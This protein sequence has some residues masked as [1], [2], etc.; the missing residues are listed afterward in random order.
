M[1]KTVA[2]KSI[3]LNFIMNVLLTISSFVFPLISFPYVSRILQPEGTGR[4]SF[5]ISFISY[6]SL[7]AQLG[8]PIYGIRACAK[9]RDNR[10]DLTRTAHEL[11]F[12]NLITS[13]ISYAA[14][15]VALI[16]IEKLKEDR[17]LFIIVSFTIILN[18]IGMEWLYKALEQYTYITVRSIILKFIALILMFIVIHDKEDYVLYGGISIF[19]T[20][21]SNIFNMINIYKYIDLRPVGNYNVKKHLKPIGIF[22]AMTCATTI[23]THMDTLM[24][25]FMSTY[26]DVG[27]YNAAIRVKNILVSIVTSL[28]TVLLP[29]VSYYIEHGLYDEFKNIS[30]KALNFV[31]IIATPIMAYFALYAKECI[32]FLSGSK[33]S[34]SIL[35]L[36]LLMPAILFIGITNILGIQILVPLGKEKIV[37]YSVIIGAIVNVVINYLLIPKYV[38]SGAAI[39]TVIAE[40]AVLIFQYLSMDVEIKKFFKQINYLKL[41]CALLIGIIGS[42]WLKVL[43]IN[44]FSIILLSSVMFFTFYFINLIIVKEELVLEIFN[45]IYGKFSKFN[46]KVKQELT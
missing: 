1:S 46:K 37:L 33:Y 9:V 25:G 7:F 31:F 17:V 34:G 45:K 2:Q 24:L 16:F 21:A 12:I 41:I 22:F 26:I 23:Y 28:G 30:K 32:Y 18:A 10:V 5:A 4:V 19:A 13:V 36:Q 40:F 14:L 39:G 20:S 3:K 27:Y 42:V 35:P 11:L 6:F 44:N 8:I 43:K 15:A 29:R 38:S